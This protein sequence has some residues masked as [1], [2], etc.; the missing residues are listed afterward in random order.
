MLVA[1]GGAFDVQA[2]DKLVFLRK[3]P[4][5]LLVVSGDGVLQFARLIAADLATF[6]LKANNAWQLVTYAVTLTQKGQMLVDAW[7]T[8]DRRRLETVLSSPA[9]SV[10]DLIGGPQNVSSASGGQC[11]GQA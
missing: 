5:N 11:G 4:P 9:S 1:I 6:T 8:G 7:M 3:V 10:A 2:I